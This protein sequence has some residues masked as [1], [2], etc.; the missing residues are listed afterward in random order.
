MIKE[1]LNRAGAKEVAVVAEGAGR[2][3]IADAKDV[4]IS[5]SGGFF[6]S[7]QDALKLCQLAVCANSGE[8]MVF[9]KNGEC[10]GLPGRS[11]LKE[12]TTKSG[13]TYKH[14]PTCLNCPGRI[15]KGALCEDNRI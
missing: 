11:E 15:G 14:E 6:M 9:V 5:L 1:L 12:M 13:K 2:K 4:G 7:E 10:P 3:V 8:L